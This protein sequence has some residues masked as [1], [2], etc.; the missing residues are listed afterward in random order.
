MADARPMTATN[1]RHSARRGA[2][3]GSGAP[4]ASPAQSPE[5]RGLELVAC[6]PILAGPTEVLFALKPGDH[7]YEYVR[8]VLPSSLE[9]LAKRLAAK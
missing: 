9:F 2:S 3:A 4:G 5:L 6:R 1:V 7:G 8:S